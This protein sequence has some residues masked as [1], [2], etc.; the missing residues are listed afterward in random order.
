MTFRNGKASCPFRSGQSI[1]DVAEANG[2]ELTA[3]CHAG[4]C[5]SDPVR[6]VEGGAHLNPMSGGERATLEDLCAV[7]PGTHR[8]ACM[9]RPTGPVVVE[10]VDGCTRRS[11][12]PAAADG[13]AA[14]R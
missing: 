5:G 3:D 8:L 12:R 13:Q 6:I 11:I 10:I 2:V 14:R 4:I 7:D 9:A 1:C